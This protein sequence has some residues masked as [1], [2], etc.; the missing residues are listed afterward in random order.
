MSRV[1]T[2]K[3]NDQEVSGHEDETILDVARENGVDIPT[4][5]YLDGLSAV[6]ACR[7]CLVEVVGVARLLPACVT[8]VSE[9]HGS[10]SR[11][12]SACNVSAHD[13]RAALQRRQPHLLCVR[14]KWALRAAGHGDQ[15]RPDH[16]ECPTASLCAKWTPPMRATAWI[17]TAAIR[18]TP[19]VCASAM[20]SKAR[21]HGI[22]WGAV[23]CQ[24]ADH[25]Y[26]HAP[27]ANRKPAPAA[28]SASKFAQQARCS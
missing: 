5:C 26:A 13:R 16:I 23:H 7:L 17:R 21:T 12:A 28:A 2:L 18:S 8:R 27:G 3:I 25:R 4:L 24:P 22:S 10:A 19:V 6:G 1:V 9:V 14:L 15:A 20:R 11:I